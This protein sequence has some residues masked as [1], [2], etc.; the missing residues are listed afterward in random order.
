MSV[1]ILRQGRRLIAS[2]QSDL[3]DSDWAS[4]R[5]NLLRRVGEERITGV[6]VDVSE[7]S[8]LD[9]YAG[10][11]LSSLGDM[12]H[13]RGAKAVVVGIQ[14]DVAFAMVQLGL[15]LGGLKTALDLDDALAILERAHA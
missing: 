8:V 5:D 11:M 15:H 6:V 12:L 13:L 2:V 14:P 1:P 7:M 9:S 10:R 4:M 3:T